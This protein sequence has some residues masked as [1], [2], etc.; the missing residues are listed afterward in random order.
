MA[1]AKVAISPEEFYKIAQA[2]DD[3]VE[4]VDGEVVSMV[5]PGARHGFVCAQVM[6][7]LGE[8]LPKDRY[9]VL[10]D[11]GWQMPSGNVRGPDACVV[12]AELIR[13]KGLPVGWWTE[14]IELAV[15]VIG[16][17]DR[18]A[19]L[20]RKTEEYFAAGARQVW[21]VNPQT[22]KLAVYRSPKDVRILAIDDEVDATDFH[23][24]LRFPA[25]RIFE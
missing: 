7:L 1:D 3:Y 19:E 2:A 21:R 12:S 11:T 16:A 9:T 23:P 13:T 20:D 8:L 22:Q 10:G 4:L 6:F 15:E 18:A 24:A 5:R 25:R 17:D 14:R